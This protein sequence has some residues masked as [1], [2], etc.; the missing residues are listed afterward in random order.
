MKSLHIITP[1]KDSIDT[2]LET[3][4]AVL[5]SKLSVPFTYTVYN[6]FST[7]ENTA[8]LEAASPATRARW[9]AV[10]AALLPLAEAGDTIRRWLR[11][12]DCD[13]LVLRPDRY[14]LGACRGDA[15]LAELSV[16]LP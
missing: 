12:R 9:T 14:L 11:E 15:A 1:V 8:R 7:P 6:D 2:T 4:R 10:D 5:D 3:V 16:R 13:A